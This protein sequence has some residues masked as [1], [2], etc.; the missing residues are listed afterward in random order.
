MKYSELKT[1]LSSMLLFG[2]F[3]LSVTGLRAQENSDLPKH[4]YRPNNQVINDTLKSDTLRPSTIEPDAKQYVQDAQQRD[5]LAARKQHILDSLSAREEFIRD[6]VLAREAFV[7][8]SIAR[9]QQIIDSLTQL[10]AQL[11]RLLDASLKALSEEIIFR[12]TA[13]RIVGD[14][15]LNDFAAYKLTYDFTAPY[16]PWK[17]LI[18][19]SDKPPV[20]RFDK[21]GGRI[22][23]IESPQF[24]CNY[25]YGR[26]PEVLVISTG[27]TILN[28]RTGNL[29]K[30][31]VDSVFFD[32]NGNVIKIKK[33]IQYYNV[34]NNYDRGSKLFLHLD[35]VKEYQYNAAGQMTRFGL[36]KFCDR[37]KESDPEKVCTITRFNIELQGNTYRITRTNDPENNY[38]DGTYTYVFSPQDVLQSASFRNVSGNENWKN[39]IEVN[40]EGNVSRYLYEKN[41]AIRQTLLVNYYHEDPSAQYKVETISCTFE[42]D[43]ISY[44]QK[45]NTTGKIRMRDRLTLEWSPWHE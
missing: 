10:T 36:I 35:Y 17:I 22:T 16:T 4:L 3:I 43:G 8:D 32:K 21:P 14:S 7:R 30:Q 20:F 26:N 6:S 1:L 11:P 15:T 44:F 42:E 39:I 9:R 37:R 25:T 41:G 31:P 29:Y 27:S 19:L 23:G 34:V 33:Y 5:S 40:E 12:T 2:M 13:I 45:N 28:R 38:S 18:N 24:T